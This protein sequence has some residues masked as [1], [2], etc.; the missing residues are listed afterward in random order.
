MPEVWKGETGGDRMAIRQSI[1]HEAIFLLC[2][3][4]MPGHD[5]Q[6]CGE[7][8]ETGLAHRKNPGERV[9]AGAV[10]AQSGGSAQDNRDRRNIS[11]ERAYLPNSGQRFGK[12]EADLV[13]WRGP[14][15]G[16]S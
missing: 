14:L 6:G 8:T 11:A 15:R 2:G 16:E 1:L 4:E 5:H 13:W 7:R 12:R 10:A 9:P 3:A